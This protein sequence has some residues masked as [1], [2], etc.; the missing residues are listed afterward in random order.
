MSAYSDSEE[1]LHVVTHALGAVL[2]VAGLSWMLSLTIASADPW[3]IVASAIYGTTLV[4]V[5]LAST[6]YHSFSQS[7]FR[8]VLKLLD[9]CAI[10]LFIAGTYTPFLLVAMRDRTGWWLFGVIWALAVCGIVLKLFLRYRFPK[11]ALASYVAMGWLVIVAGP[12]VYNAIGPE[13]FGWLVAGGV[14]Y[15]VG[16]AAYAAKRVPYH[17][18]IWHVFVL[19]GGLCHFNAVALYVLPTI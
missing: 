19:V 2:A 14:A 17:H 13:C 11:L 16:A 4:A 1:R 3:R 15:T 8:H 6:V 12:A 18:T 9:H 10:Y 7:R 5:F